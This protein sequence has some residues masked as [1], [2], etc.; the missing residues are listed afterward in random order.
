MSTKRTKPTCT[1]P[2]KKHRQ[3]RA[4]EIK[5]DGDAWHYRHPRTKKADYWSLCGQSEIGGRVSDDNACGR[6][7]YIRPLKGKK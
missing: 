6:W 7:I 4:N 3:L 1:F 2:R 5:R